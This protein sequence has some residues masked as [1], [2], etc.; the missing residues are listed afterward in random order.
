MGSVSMA[1]L[2]RGNLLFDAGLLE[3]PP[4]IGAA[5]VG[6]LLCPLEISA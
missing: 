2:V 6:P 1:Q 5:S 3:H 4:Q